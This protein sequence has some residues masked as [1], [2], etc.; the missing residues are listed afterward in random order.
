M[1]GKLQGVV[2]ERQPATSHPQSQRMESS[3][4]DAYEVEDK[5]INQQRRVKLIG[6]RIEVC[7]RIQGKDLKGLWDTGAQVS[8]VSQK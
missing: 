4:K 3:L 1:L 7:C 2:G 6:N 5:T 8:L